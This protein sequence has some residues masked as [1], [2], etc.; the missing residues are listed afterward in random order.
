[1]KKTDLSTILST[2]FGLGY[3][4]FAPG[5]FGSLAAFGLYLLLPK[6]LF[7][8]SARY[9]STAAVLLFALLFVPVVRRAERLLG[10]DSP[11]IVIDE[12]FGYLL[13]VMFLP[14]TFMIGLWAFILFRVFDIAK[15]FPINRS[16]AIG[17]GF[18]VMID[19]LLAGLYANILLQFI[20]ILQ[21]KFFGI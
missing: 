15:P 17:K 3:I 1:M 11:K 21:P 9:I 10:E 18:G 8:G 4:P 13:A 2:C 6:L 12:V 20:I 16:Q 14:K 7:E 19:D 5:T